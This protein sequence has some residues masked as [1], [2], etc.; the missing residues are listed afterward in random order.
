MRITKNMVVGKVYALKLKNV[1]SQ[2]SNTERLERAEQ[3]KEATRKVYH[4]P[5]LPY[6]PPSR[7]FP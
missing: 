5:S 7:V 2:G 3:R 4:V 6:I 1:H